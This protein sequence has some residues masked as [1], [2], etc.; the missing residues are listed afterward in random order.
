METEHI[1]QTKT[2]GYKI[3]ALGI[4]EIQRK[5]DEAVAQTAAAKSTNFKLSKSRDRLVRMVE[6]ENVKRSKASSARKRVDE[7]LAKAKESLEATNNLK[8]NIIGAS[9]KLTHK[10]EDIKKETAQVK[11]DII[12]V[13]YQ[14]AVAQ[15]DTEIVK[16]ETQKI[17]LEKASLALS[18]NTL[19]EKIENTKDQLHE[20][21]SN[22]EEVVNGLAETNEKTLEI[23]RKKNNIEI[24][25]K[26]VTNEKL[27]NELLDVKVNLAVK[28]GEASVRGTI[29]DIRKD[30]VRGMQ[31]ELAV[32]QEEKKENMRTA[33]KLQKQQ[34]YVRVLLKGEQAAAEEEQKELDVLVKE[35]AKMIYRKNNKIAR[36]EELLT[37]VRAKELEVVNISLLS[38][39]FSHAVRSSKPISLEYT[40]H[41]AKNNERLLAAEEKKRNQMVSDKWYLHTQA[42][43]RE[44][45]K[46]IQQAVIQTKVPGGQG[47]I[48]MLQKDTERIKT[49]NAMLA[50]HEKLAAKELN[51]IQAEIAEE[52][53]KQ[54]N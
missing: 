12:F 9:N 8:I 48:E 39:S 50:H 7:E 14:T 53:K 47:S 2:L 20:Q 1:A 49:E 13:E 37:E 10:V 29:L 23:N 54:R 4:T 35:N 19:E 16:E 28:Q 30:D 5:L 11:K 40:K 38:D 41:T 42:L 24:Q 31:V 27:S 36:H 43:N 15:E 26:M 17:K 22:I 6:N 32:T 21:Q 33:T 52:G 18:K 34:G 51:S 25:Q 3:E 44:K 45:E 46:R